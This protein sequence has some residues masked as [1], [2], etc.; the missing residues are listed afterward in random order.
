MSLFK[1]KLTIIPVRMVGTA[2][3]R[4]FVIL[5]AIILFGTSSP[6][7]ERKRIRTE[8]LRWHPDRFANKFGT[9]LRASDRDRV[10][11]RVKQ[12]SQMLNALTT[13]E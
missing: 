10:L 13:K 12:V 9:R 6:D 3:D 1:V 4:C 8:L 2:P 11:E 5:Q 7:E